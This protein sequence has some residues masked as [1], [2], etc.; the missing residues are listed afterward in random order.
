MSDLDK[1]VFTL[2]ELA[3]QFKWL[4]TELVEGV[5]SWN[6]EFN[7][8]TSQA[9]IILFEVLANPP[10]P[11]AD[12]PDHLMQPPIG[13]SGGFKMKWQDGCWLPTREWEEG[14]DTEH[15][16][17]YWFVALRWLYKEKPESGVDVGSISEALEYPGTWEQ[18]RFEPHRAL[19]YYD[20]F[21]IPIL[22]ASETACRYL[23]RVTG[24]VAPKETTKRHKTAPR[25]IPKDIEMLGRAAKLVKLIEDQEQNDTGRALD[26]MLGAVGARRETFGT[27]PHFSEARDAWSRLKSARPGKVNDRGHGQ[28]ASPE[29]KTCLSCGERFHEYDCP[30]CDKPPDRCRCCHLEKEHDRIVS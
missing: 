17:K 25:K 29:Y 3:E 11:L 27:S 15:W 20:G 24:A 13:C 26:A 2:G 9:G 12:C 8:R 14:S 7:S 22:R 21:C 28:S 16:D 5:D 1:W 30:E 4:R 6:M 19:D 23:S 18:G 10:P